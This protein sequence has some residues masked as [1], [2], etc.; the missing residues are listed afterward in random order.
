[1]LD[2]NL[3]GLCELF[4]NNVHA[5]RGAN[6]A[7]APNYRIGSLGNRD[8]LAVDGSATNFSAVTLRVELVLKVEKFNN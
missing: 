6:R 3:S 8:K 5:R 7:I 4:E 1:M 2:N